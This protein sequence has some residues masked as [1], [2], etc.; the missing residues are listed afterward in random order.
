ME[1]CKLAATPM[2]Q[3][4]KSL[5]GC[6]MI[7]IATMPYVMHVVSQLSRYMNCASEIHF[8]V[9]KRI[10]RYVKGTIDYGI[11]LKIS[12]SMVIRIV[13]RLD[14]LMICVAP[15]VTVLVLVLEFFLGV[16]KNKK[17][18]HHSKQKHNIW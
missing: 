5:I 16:R 13:T 7:L 14:V 15:Y 3:K 12:I 11:K 17:L 2:N 18:L 6:L 10:L 1:A 8:Q 9:A 4:E